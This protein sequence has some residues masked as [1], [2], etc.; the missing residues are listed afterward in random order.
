MI[1][2]PEE[3]GIGLVLGI[4]VCSWMVW[5]LSRL[6][7][8]TLPQDESVFERRSFLHWFWAGVALKIII[9]VAWYLVVGG[10]E[11]N[12][13]VGDAEGYDALG[14]NLAT[15]FREG[16]FYL[17]SL[18]PFLQDQNPGFYYWV[19]LVYALFGHHHI[20]ISLWNSLFSIW[21]AVL[22]FQSCRV[23]FGL[24]AAKYS[25][26]LV[27]F[28]PQFISASYYILKDVMVTFFVTSCVWAVYVPKRRAH[29]FVLL[30]IA[31]FC[32][33]Q[34]RPQLSI[35][36]GS[37]G[38]IQ[39]W[40]LM[41]KSEKQ[42]QAIICGLA[43]LTV[44][45]MGTHMGSG[46][47]PLIGQTT[48]IPYV[49]P[50]SKDDSGLVEGVRLTFSLESIQEVSRVIM[51]KPLTFFY[52]SIY[53]TARLFYGPF[54]LYAR[55]G[56]NLR[57]YDPYESGFRTIMESGS[58]F[59]TGLAMP[60]IIIGL[61]YCLW[62]RGRDAFLL[63]M[64]IFAGCAMLILVGVIIRWRLPLMP[65]VLS[66]GGFGLTVWERIKP[67]YPIYIMLFILLIVANATLLEGMIVPKCAVFVMALFM[68]WYFLKRPS[69][70]SRLFNI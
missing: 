6:L 57:P 61:L 39:L 65:T 20:L 25:F 8:R 34:F 60:M 30:L 56:P 58:G 47:G 3:F 4:A 2:G 26:V 16:N 28:Y 50:T 62:V 10:H 27:L 7:V 63:Y 46:D 22:V 42:R 19:G 45:F 51:A 29:R 32:L 33:S 40:L 15:S 49:A 48:K 35:I 18:P 14:W 36:I 69:V 11:F 53:A 21:S 52:Q 24:Q 23:L 41:W 43:S 64:W 67:I 44:L 55:E 68:L 37:L 59:Q 66:F 70:K 12:P 9:I 5:W 17:L 13:S 54:F 31:L 1:W 38:F